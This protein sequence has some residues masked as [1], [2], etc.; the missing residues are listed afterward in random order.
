MQHQP[1]VFLVGDKVRLRGK[2][3]KLRCV[4]EVAWHPFRHEFI[5]IVETSAPAHRA[6]YLPYWF[7]AQLV[8]EHD[9]RME[10]Q[11]TLR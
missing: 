3:D 4:L 7:A 10:G 6:P 5:Y 1:P 9:F 11:N 8:L 2:L